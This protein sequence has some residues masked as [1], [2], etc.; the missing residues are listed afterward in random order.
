M[1]DIDNY[2]PEWD[3]TNTWELILIL[4]MV[5]HIL[6]ALKKEKYTNWLSNYKIINIPPEGTDAYIEFPDNINFTTTINGVETEITD[7]F[8]R[9]KLTNT[10]IYNDTCR[11]SIH[12]NSSNPRLW[13][14]KELNTNTLF[15]IYKL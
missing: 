7:F 4:M 13:H 10:D 6:R 3:F 2:L 15:G 8:N 12:Y 1:K 5:I 14:L 9:K 11:G